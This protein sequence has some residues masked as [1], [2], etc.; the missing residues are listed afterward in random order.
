MFPDLW[1]VYFEFFVSGS[2][3][4]FPRAGGWMARLQPQWVSGVK[5]EALKY[6]V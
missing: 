3:S 6:L 2:G 5:V 4:G 1:V